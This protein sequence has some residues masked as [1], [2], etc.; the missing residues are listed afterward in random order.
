MVKK[1]LIAVTGGKGG[2]GKS[3]I[4]TALAAE[5][6]E[7]GRVLLVDLDVD[8]PNDHLLCSAVPKKFRDVFSM[9]PEFDLEKCTKCGECA[10][11]CH[12][13]AILFVKLK[14]PVFF[15]DLCSGC[16]ACQIA[17][18]KIAKAISV[19][20]TKIGEI[21]IAKPDAFDLLSG[22]LKV[23]CAESAPVVRAAKD[24]ALKRQDDYDY[25]VFDTAPG[26]HCNVIAAL[27]GVDIAIAV[28]EPTPL[29]AHDLGLILKLFEELKLRGGVVINK[30]TVGDKNEV[31]D[32]VSKYSSNVLAEVPYEDGIVSA[33]SHGRII[34]HEAISDL[35]KKV[36][37]T[38]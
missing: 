12:T 20:S 11:V 32:I 2:T 3:T 5:L 21:T 9:V 15:E 38:A 27:L 6:G 19:G 14:F 29:G 25:I 22:F 26:A 1:R 36:L 4:A 35:A 30:S 28:T 31:V 16:S 34:E 7:Q 8:C 18:S 23:G 37:E 24:E 17:C 33:Y 13:N 10:K